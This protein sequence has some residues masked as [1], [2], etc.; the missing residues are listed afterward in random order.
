MALKKQANG[1][2]KHGASMGRQSKISEYF[3]IVY[4]QG[5]DD[6]GGGYASVSLKKSL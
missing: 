5:G 2:E 3:R 6:D 1:S 4:G